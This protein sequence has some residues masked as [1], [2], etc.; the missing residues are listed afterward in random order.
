[1]AALG[2]VGSDVRNF[3]CP[4]CGAHDRER[5]LFLYL[6]ALNLFEG[7]RGKAIL[8]F[9]PERNLSKA[10]HNARPDLYVCCDLFPD[11]YAKIPDVQQ[12]DISSIAYASDSFDIVIASHVLEHVAYD[13]TA[14]AE[15]QRVLKSGG[16]AILQTPYCAKLHATWEDPGIVDDGARLQAYGKE[17]HVRLYGRDIFDR[18]ASSGL[19]SEVRSHEELLS[20]AD[21]T[22]E[23]VNQLEPLFLFRKP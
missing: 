4:S 18:I 20:S 2:S 5:H 8:H 3:E 13:M 10:I 7:M 15:V 23:G 6:R 9:A 14:L 19:A 17:D 22:V 21:A 16:Y 11:V 12:M 1:M